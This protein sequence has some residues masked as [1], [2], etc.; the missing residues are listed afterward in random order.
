MLPEAWREPLLYHAHN[1][2]V[3]FWSMMG[4]LGVAAFVWLEVAFWHIALRLRVPF[5]PD[6][7]PC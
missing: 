6:G 3:D 7:A 5:S 1:A 2:V 4:I